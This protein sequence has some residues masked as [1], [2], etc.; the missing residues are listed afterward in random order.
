MWEPRRRDLIEQHRFYVSE[1]KKRLTSQFSDKTKLEE[2]ADEFSDQWLEKMGQHFDPDRHDPAEF[3]EQAHDEGIQHYAA[4]EEL[5]NSA[6]LA[7]ISGMYHLWEKS[8]RDWLTSVDGIGSFQVGQNLPLAIWKSNFTQVLELF[9]CVGLYHAGCPTRESLDTCRM[10]VNTYKHGAGPSEV[11]LKIRRPELFD[12]YGWRS[13]FAYSS[14]AD[15]TDYTDL[16]VEDGVIDEFADSIEAFWTAL[17]EHI[18]EKEFQP[19]PS[20]F[21]KAFKKDQASVYQTN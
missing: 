11:E 3:Y 12:Q 21:L 15:L 19:V 7:L 14:I 13:S 5:G 17:P 20:W 2:E 18:T 16:Y 6:R 10:V 4:L 9:E 8:L 1:G